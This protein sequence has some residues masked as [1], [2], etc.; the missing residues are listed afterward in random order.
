LSSPHSQIRI[1]NTGTTAINLN[2]VSA[3]YWLNYD[4]TGQ[5]VQAYVDYAGKMPQGTNVTSN[6]QVSVVST[7]LGTQTHYVR[8]TFTG[9][10]T[11]QPGE[12]IEVQG[13]FNKSD[14]SAMLQNNDWSYA[15]NTGFTTWNRITGYVNGALV[16]GQE[17]TAS[18]GGAA[19]VASVLSYPNPATSA[20]GAT[21][22]YTISGSSSVSAASVHAL[23]LNY[24]IP[25][26]DAKVELK[27]YTVTGRLLWSREMTGVGNVSAGNHIVSWD[28]KTPG[29]QKLAAGTYI[30]KVSVL[31]NG[32]TSSKS[33]VIIILN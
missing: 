16:W 32:T 26:P 5:S 17:P 10:I 20:T 14:W 21:L 31:S 12:Y 15:A 33:F 3:R 18:T 29:G 23:D 13:R 8:Y 22:S 25:D 19:V 27:I 28:G 6:V 30:L 11:L 9:G 7:T 1:V 24:S 4:G 2:T